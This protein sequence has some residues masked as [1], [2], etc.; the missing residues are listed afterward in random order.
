MA[1]ASPDGLV[2]EDGLIEIKCP[3]LDTHLQY[4][5]DDE[6]PEE[7]LPQMLWQLACTERQWIDFVSYHPDCPEPYRLFVKRLDRTKESDA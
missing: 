3:R 5:A 6:I 4:L 2:G 1:G 7:Y